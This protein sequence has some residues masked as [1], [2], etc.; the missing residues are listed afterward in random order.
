[1]ATA[2]LNTTNDRRSRW[3]ALLGLAI[4]LAAGAGLATFFWTTDLVNGEY[5]AGLQS[6][7]DTAQSGPGVAVAMA[8]ALAIGASMVVLPCGFPAVFAVPTI[9]EGERHT[10]G[11]LRALT[12]FTL[13]GVIPLAVAGLL[14]GLAGD[15][16]WELLSTPRSRMWFA[17]ITYSLLGAGAVAYALSEFGLIHVRA[18]FERVTGPS[19][20]GQD[21]PARRSFVLGATFGGGLGIACPMPTYYALIG[22]VVVAATAW[23]GALVLG[24]YALGRML[25]PVVLGLLIVA[26]ASRRT[27]SERMAAIHG[28]VQWASG[29]VMAGLG[30]FMVTLFGGFLG[31][32]LL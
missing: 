19:L 30:V 18:A 11:R 17:A 24:A 6:R 26:G 2:A 16:V 20:P 22:W 27:V 28:R 10:A 3:P 32:S 1:M 29:V 31:V 13:G 4:A 14:L 5:I 25:V 15:S 7:L 23:Y 9:L 21:A 12:A 8:I